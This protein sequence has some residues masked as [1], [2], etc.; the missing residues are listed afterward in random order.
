MTLTFLHNLS[1]VCFIDLFRRYFGSLANLTD[2][3]MVDKI[4]ISLEDC[5]NIDIL[6]AGLFKKL[7]LE[8][9]C[10]LLVFDKE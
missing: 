3:Q 8:N 4:P 5:R 10:N 2:Q 9:V 1:I 7:L 6:R